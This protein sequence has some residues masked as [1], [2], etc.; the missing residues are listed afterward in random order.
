[1][2]RAYGSSFPTVATKPG[3]NMAWTDWTLA[4]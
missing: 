2:N 3:K 4:R 1:V